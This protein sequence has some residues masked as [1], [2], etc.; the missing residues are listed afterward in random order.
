MHLYQLGITALIFAA[1]F[2]SPLSAPEPSD[3]RITL[4]ITPA[5]VTVANSDEEAKKLHDEGACGG[6][7]LVTCRELH[8][9]RASGAITQVEC[10]DSVFV[11]AS[12]LQG[13]AK[14]LRYNTAQRIVTLPGTAPVFFFD[15]G[16]RPTTEQSADN[17]SFQFGSL[18]IQVVPVYTISFPPKTKEPPTAAAPNKAFKPT[19]TSPAN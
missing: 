11:T 13:H 8:V 1:I 17:I 3:A 18:F 16:R 10:V 5:R 19:P 2:G 14:L 12:G 15:P 6:G 9:T 7:V 4:L